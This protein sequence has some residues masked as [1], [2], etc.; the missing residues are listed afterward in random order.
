MKIKD[1]DTDLQD[2]VNL[3]N[4][5]EIISGKK[6]P[7]FIAH[8][9][10]RYLYIPTL[11]LQIYLNKFIFYPQVSEDRERRYWNKIYTIARGE[12]GQYWSRGYS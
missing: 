9:K 4:L 1:F 3:N 11:L 5:L 7:K 10:S 8:P 2:G 12:I 6:L